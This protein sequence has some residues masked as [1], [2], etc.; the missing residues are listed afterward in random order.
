MANDFDVD[1]HRD[2]Q[3]VFIHLAGELDIMSGE[4][5]NEELE[6]AMQSAPEQIVLDLG[7]LTF[8]DSAGLQLILAAE[9]GCRTEFGSSLS[10]IPGPRA[11]MRIL[12]IT[13]V[14]NLLN[15]FSASGE[16]SALKRS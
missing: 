8:M 2:G 14:D 13:G 9:A 5:F 7:R 10:I 6:L 12:E 15:C 16:K 1:T 3:T 11:V 4:A